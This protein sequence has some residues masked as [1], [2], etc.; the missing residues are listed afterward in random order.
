MDRISLGRILE[1]KIH[2]REKNILD[3]MND[4]VQTSK[5]PIAFFE[6]TQGEFNSYYINFDKTIVSQ[7]EIM[8]SYK[9]ILIKVKQ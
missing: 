8:Y 5:K 7:N 6:L 9:G 2:Y 4:A 3:K 1:M